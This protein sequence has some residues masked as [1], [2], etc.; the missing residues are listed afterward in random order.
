MQRK[1]KFP[2]F[3]RENSHKILKSFLLYLIE[4]GKTVFFPNVV[5]SKIVHEEKHKEL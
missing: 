5:D 3:L 4:N 1:N 2:L